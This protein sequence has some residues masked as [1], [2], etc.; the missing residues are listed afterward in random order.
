MTAYNNSFEGGSNGTTITTGNSGGTSGD[1]FDTV[2]VGTT[3]TLAFDTTHAAHGTLALKVQQGVTSAASFVEKT[4]PSASAT[5]AIRLY[6]YVTANP[7]VTVDVGKVLSGSTVRARL[8]L[9]NTGKLVV[10]DSA[11]AAVI[12][13]AGTVPLNA[14]FRVEAQFPAL[15]AT[16][17]QVTLARFNT[18]DS[19][20]AT[21]TATST[22]LQNFG[23]TADRVRYGVTTA[24]ATIGPFW[25]DDVAEN[26]T[27]SAIGPAVTNV[28]APATLA[29]EGTLTAAASPAFPVPAGLSGSGSLSTGGTPAMTV[30]AGLTGDGSLAVSGTPAVTA[31]ATFTGDGTLASAG[32]PDLAVG[33]AFTGDGTL[34]TSSAPAAG[35]DGQ[36]TGSGALTA[37]GQPAISTSASFTGSG[38]LATV[39]AAGL[40]GAATFTGGGQLA[41]AQRP[42]LVA[43][44]ALTGDGTLTT[45]GVKAITLPTPGGRTYRVSAEN[46]TYAVA[47][48]PRRVVVPAEVRATPVDI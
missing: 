1:A 43:T 5:V 46:R 8:R 45:V 2:T 40:T 39:T 32:A 14:W 33:A 10:S 25:L 15:S 6:M 47:A 26:D 21:E 12:T 16:V 22:A 24:A 27:A 48:E 23:G 3:G 37:G 20:V 9:T 13:Q 35:A 29:G 11:N 17:G 7:G 44:A 28:S 34:T 41:T 42:G 30:P 31:T 38:Q 19:A 18:A 4:F 36:L